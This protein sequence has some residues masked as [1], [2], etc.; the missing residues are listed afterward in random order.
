[1]HIHSAKQMVPQWQELHQ[2]DLIQLAPAKAPRFRLAKAEPPRALALVGAD[3]KTRAVGPIP[4]TPEDM[5]STWR[6]TL[7]PAD[8]G[9]GTRLVGRGL[10]CSA[11]LR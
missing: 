6:W 8:R 2:G 5:A 7:R 1:M 4:A 10:V 9:R 11:A 3:P